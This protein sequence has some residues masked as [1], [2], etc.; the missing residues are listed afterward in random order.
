MRVYRIILAGTIAGTL[1]LSC[2]SSPT[3]TTGK[4][5]RTVTS[6]SK[7]K[8]SPAP[9]TSPS[10][11]NPTDGG[12]TEPT[13][14]PSSDASTDPT[15]TPTATA[16]TT[17]Q[18]NY[19]GE[20]VNASGSAVSGVKIDAYNATGTR[21]GSEATTNA[22][23]QFSPDSGWTFPATLI[24]TATDGT[25]AVQ[26]NVAKT[27]TGL[28]FTLG[29]TG[30]IDG[31]L[32]VSGGQTPDFSNTQITIAGLSNNAT[33][34][35]LGTFLMGELPPG[36][37]YTVKAT[38]ATL[39]TGSASVTVQPGQTANVTINLAVAGAAG[40]PTISALSQSNGGPGATVTITGTNFGKS[41]GKTA[42]VSFGG[43]AAT[44]VT[45]TSDTSLTATVPTGAQT[46]NLTVTVDGNTSNAYAF[47]VLSSLKLTPSRMMLFQGDAL[48][49]G[50]VGTDTNG[51]TVN[52]PA[53][54]WSHSGSSLSVTSTGLVTAGSAGS[55]TLTAKS[56]NT[57]A[58]LGV[59]VSSASINVSTF[60]G[61]ATQGAT[62][63]TGGAASFEG[64]TG[65]AFDKNHNVFYVG[66]ET[67]DFQ[68]QT[69]PISGATVRAISTSAAVTTLAGQSGALGSANG[70]G[71]G[72][73]FGGV[74]G[75]AVDSQGNVFVVDHG[76]NTIREITSTGVVSTF[77]GNGTAGHQDGSGT[78]AEFS[79]PWG[80]AIDSNDNLYV[81]ERGVAAGTTPVG[82]DDI[83]KITPQRVVSTLAGGTEGSANGTG[84]AAQFN[85]PLGIVA[86][87][88]GNLYVSD[89][90][91]SLIRK[92]TSAGVV[93]TFA[94]TGQTQPQ[95]GLGTAGSVG[96]PTGLAMDA[97][98][99]LFVEDAL[100]N[101]ILE[102]SPAGL[103]TRI[104]G[105][106]DP[107]DQ[108]GPGR[109]A[110]FNGLEG[111]AVD[112]SGNLYAAENNGLRVRKISFQ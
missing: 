91:N 50:A 15:P 87:S 74:Y 21:S 76:N 78:T 86:D 2:V 99:N 6:G 53:V 31:T 22:Q 112:A 4:L 64:P 61:S 65:I 45:V 43:V 70:T 28:K 67:T 103:V 71:S 56:G 57:T 16:T 14:T 49:Y 98:G 83:R 47:A 17:T 89:N 94:G 58:S 27:A 60:A 19:F 107:G 110:S 92:V 101:L 20:V 36:S 51:N 102:I 39:G 38:D 82:N 3:Q 59:T 32:A 106:M 100:N 79:D 37:G 26:F 68:S 46:G 96:Y 23:G 24:A 13:A 42:S 62:N 33:S 84:S 34:N 54:N 75:V 111:L 40:S 90:G 72:A 81:T 109:N 41:T 108:D 7:T 11:S 48:Q 80:L 18:A 29:Q 5:Q 95:D 97:S 12:T 9:S 1:T 10:D 63:G 93:S 44:S 104:A 85:T 55:D 73:T 77:A 69:L 35:A 88:Q 66:D 105:D 25:E 8:L 30:E 52:A